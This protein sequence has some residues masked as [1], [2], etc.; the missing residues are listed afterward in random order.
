MKPRTAATTL[1][2]I[3]DDKS[4]S[5]FRIIFESNG[6]GSDSLRA[7]AGLSRKRYYSRLSKM[8]QAGLVKRKGSR[9]TMTALG[10]IVYD[11]QMRIDSALGIYRKIK[12][13]A[14]R[15]ISGGLPKREQ[16]RL[17]N[18]LLDNVELWKIIEKK[19]EGTKVGNFLS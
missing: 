17:F 12:T 8:T 19:D 9:Y 13:L 7:K 6:I 10:K 11:S 15:E 1:R 14:G 5:L 16:Q 4:M 3:A 18:I 2:A